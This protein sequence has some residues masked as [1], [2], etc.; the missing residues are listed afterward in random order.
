MFKEMR[1]QS[2]MDMTGRVDLGGVGI[3]DRI[4]IGLSFSII[5]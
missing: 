5:K 1:K 3:S 2:R 4:K